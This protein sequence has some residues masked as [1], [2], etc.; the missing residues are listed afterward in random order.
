MSNL[1]QYFYVDEIS[2]PCR[3]LDTHVVKEDPKGHGDLTKTL[4]TLRGTILDG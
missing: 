2:N 1:M 4:I 3:D